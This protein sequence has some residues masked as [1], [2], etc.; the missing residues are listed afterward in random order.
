M[1]ARSDVEADIAERIRKIGGIRKP[2]S[3]NS[4]IYQD[5]HISGDDA[6]E[7]LEE[8]VK[9]YGTSFHG[10]SFAAYFPNETEALFYHIMSCLGF[11]DRAHKSVTLSHLTAVVEQGAWFDPDP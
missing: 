1:V 3:K 2:L 4:R 10:F 5:L 11:P 7:L 6:A 9:T 8:I